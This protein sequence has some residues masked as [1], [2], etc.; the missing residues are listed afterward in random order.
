M[1]L[2]PSTTM[3]G[4][5]T[6]NYCKLDQTLSRGALILQA[7][8]APARKGSGHARLLYQFVYKIADTKYVYYF[9]IFTA[10][11]PMMGLNVAKRC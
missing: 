10:K 3:L 11:Q 7:I 6:S 5:R 2:T 4:A 1:Q 8:N 9:D